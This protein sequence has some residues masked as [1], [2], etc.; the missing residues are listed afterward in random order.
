MTMPLASGKCLS[1]SASTTR[2]TVHFQPLAADLYALDLLTSS[3]KALA[4]SLEK[5]FT[6][7]CPPRSDC[8]RHEGYSGIALGHLGPER[9]VLLRAADRARRV[10]P[11]RGAARDAARPRHRLRVRGRLAVAR[12]PRRAG[13]RRDDPRADPPRAA[14]SAAHPSRAVQPRAPRLGGRHAFRPGSA[15]PARGAS[16][17]RRRRR[18]PAP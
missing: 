6:A 12:R 16:S 17:P 9:G 8:F 14:L 7:I 5:A 3:L 1:G 11:L 4:H 10:V 18:A 13:G 15:H 2:P